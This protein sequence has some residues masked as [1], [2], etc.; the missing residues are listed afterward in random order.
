MI[1]PEDGEYRITIK[2]RHADGFIEVFKA[3][4]VNNERTEI[5]NLESLAWVYKVF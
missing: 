2:A 5:C 3:R 4:E 1:V